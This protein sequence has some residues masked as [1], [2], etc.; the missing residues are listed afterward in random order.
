MQSVM[1][2]L[3]MEHERSHW[4]YTAR[5]DIV[6][7]LLRR[8][9]AGRAG[10]L[11][12]LDIGCGAGGML[13]HL[14]AFG[15]AIGVDPS[16]AA[17]EF[18]RSSSGLDIREGALPDALPFAATER[19]DVVTLLDVVEHVDD[20]AA[21][22]RAVHE[23][24]VPGGTAIITVPAFPF[25]WSGHDVVNEHRR[26]YVRRE[27]AARLREAGFSIRL[28]SYYN[29]TLFLPISAVRLARRLLPGQQE[30]QPDIGRMPRPL[31]ALLHHLFAAERFAL[32][33]TRLPFGVSLIAVARRERHA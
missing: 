33:A 14:A 32:P 12:L 27:L 24:L 21:S 7:A 4:W 3:H 26:R 10:P 23:L 30:P 31:N 28:L 29:M 6:L 8:E 15:E 1:Y 20:D 17:L 19:F 16:P 18:A 13:T 25:L 2:D 9:L 22:L 5:R 11:R